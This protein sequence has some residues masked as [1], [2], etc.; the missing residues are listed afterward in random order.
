MD[1]TW[2]FIGM[3]VERAGM[4]NLCVRCLGCQD[5]FGETSKWLY[6]FSQLYGHVGTA[7]D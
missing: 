2:D 6:F 1:R 7:E 3:V 4:F 5:R